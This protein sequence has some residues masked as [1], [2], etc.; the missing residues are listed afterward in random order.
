M[1]WGGRRDLS[2]VNGRTSGPTLEVHMDPLTIAGQYYDAWQH[3]AGDMTD[4]PLAKDYAFT[5]PVAS[6]DSA[7][8]F[9]E[10]ARQAGAAVRRFRVRR[11]FVDGD[12]VCSIIDWEMDPLPGKTLTSAELLHIRDGEIVE[13]ELIYDA[14][15]L[16]RVMA[17]MGSV[18]PL[19]GRS[20]D[21][22]AELIGQISA[23]GWDAPSTCA[24]WT[25]RQVANHLAGGLLLLTRIV[26]GETVDSA[27]FDGQRQADT[28]HLGSDPEAGFRA[29]TD[30]SLAVF[31]KPDT[32]SREF[33]YRGAQIPGAALAS[34]SLLESF[35]HGWDIARG[36]GLPYP[37]DDDIVEAVWAFAKDAVD[38]QQRRAG[39]WAEA[40]P[41]S[42][43][44]APVTALLAH[45]GRRV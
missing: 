4:V 35:V 38:D 11:Q 34:I 2:G 24:E 27:E 29:V 26:E 18:I 40:V 23:D 14:E 45:L 15:D 30:R 16:R 39:L 43:T 31:A 42:P 22:V 20:Y 19:L 37:A 36:A 17:Q 5:G 1:S 13:G 41:I 12:V 9:R 33:P 6:F 44:A 21:V 28:E 10:M 3:R 25:V 7:D 8:G 32:L